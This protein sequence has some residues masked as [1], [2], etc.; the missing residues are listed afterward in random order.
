MNRTLFF[1]IGLVAVVPI[2]NLHAKPTPRLE[3]LEPVYEFGTVDGAKPVSHTFQIRNAGD[4]E[5]LIRKIHA[6]CGCTSFL[7]SN[8]TLPPGA[9]LGIPVTVSSDETGSAPTI[10]RLAPADMRAA[11]AWRGP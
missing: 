5:L 6:P 9:T 11:L 4:A 8:K 2:W 3:C 10:E 1:C 7:L